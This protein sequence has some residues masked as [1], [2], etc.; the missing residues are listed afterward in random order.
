MRPR[1]AACSPRRTAAARASA[2]N[3]RPLPLNLRSDPAEPGLRCS[4]FEVATSSVAGVQSVFDNGAPVTPAAWI[5]DGTLTELIRTRA[6]AA[7]TGARGALRRRKP[8]HGR[9]GAGASL[10]EMIASTDRGLLLTCLWYIRQVDPQNLLLTGLTRDGVYLV[11][12]GQ[13]RG[14]VNNFRF[15]ESPVDLLGR[16]PRD[17]PH[18]AHALAR[19]ERRLHPHG[20]ARAA[21]ARL[22]HVDGQSGHLSSN[23][24]RPGGRIHPVRTMFVSC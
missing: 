12:D 23:H 3:C 4:P 11:E 5:T 19:V 2:S 1:A 20:H 15:N 13:V 16:G 8:D 18:R 10:D 9:C 6:W 17:R 22:Q 7:R 14:A 21:G 24:R